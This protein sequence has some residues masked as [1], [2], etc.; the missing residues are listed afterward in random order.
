MPDKTQEPA[1]CLEPTQVSYY[2]Y[3]D[4]VPNG[5]GDGFPKGNKIVDHGRRR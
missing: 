2:R 5:C 4:D 1:I 3:E